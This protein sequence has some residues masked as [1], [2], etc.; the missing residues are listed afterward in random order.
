MFSFPTRLAA[1]RHVPIYTP[2]D[3]AKAPPPQSQGLAGCQGGCATALPWADACRPLPTATPCHSLG[4]Q[5]TP[6]CIPPHSALPCPA[7]PASCIKV[8]LLPGA[9]VSNPQPQA[10]AISIP[11]LC[12]S[13]HPGVTGPA[14]SSHH[15]NASDVPLCHPPHHYRQ[16]RGNCSR[17][18]EG[19]IHRSTL[20]GRKV[21]H[22]CRDLIFLPQGWIS[23]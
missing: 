3:P 7:N 4:T 13:S 9:P 15:C 11:P 14:A 12:R 8:F 21:S 18:G 17:G 19:K 20:A 5:D 2:E 6:H 16:R 10:I 22:C 1:S 23:L